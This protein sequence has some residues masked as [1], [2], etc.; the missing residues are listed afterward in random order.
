M[1][2]REAVTQGAKFLA[3]AKFQKKKINQ[4]I[5]NEACHAID[6]QR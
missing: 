4:A 3:S 6:K 5:I 1:G 2:A